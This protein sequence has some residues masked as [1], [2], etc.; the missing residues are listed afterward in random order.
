MTQRF[1][2]FNYRSIAEMN[3]NE[4]VENMSEFCSNA[5]VRESC[6]QGK[7]T[8]LSFQA[9]QVCRAKMKLQLINRDI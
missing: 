6:Q 7:Q 1:G 4:L 5:Q 8:K 3:K 2:H 9:N